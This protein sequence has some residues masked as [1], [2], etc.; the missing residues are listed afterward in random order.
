MTYL[1]T[2]IDHSRA[3]TSV[4]VRVAIWGL[5]GLVAVIFAV[6]GALKFL[7]PLLLNVVL[8]FLKVPRDR[9]VSEPQTVYYD[10]NTHGIYH[11]KYDPNLCGS[12][13]QD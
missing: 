12:R 7:L 4:P 1:R 11:P 6:W 5:I 3:E 2:L 10:D 9:G 8:L 13:E